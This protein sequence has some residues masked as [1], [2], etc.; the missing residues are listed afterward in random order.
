MEDHE[1]G[2]CSG[3][4]LHVSWTTDT[5]R[6]RRNNEDACLALPEKGLLAVSDG[7]GGEFAGEVASRFVIQWLPRLLER[8][9]ES[10]PDGDLGAVEEALRDVLNDLNHRL[11]SESS[12][13]DGLNKMG[14][15]LTMF[16]VR[17]GHAHVAHLGDSR[18]YLCRAGRLTKLS[19]DHGVVGMLLEQ[20]VISLDEARCH[21]LRG[22]LS[23]YMGM[24]GNTKAEVATVELEDGDR[25]MLCTDG[26]TDGL[27]DQDIEGLLAA[28]QDLGSA[29]ARLVEAAKHASG[30]DNIT[31][32]LA[33]WHGR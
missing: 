5:G 3:G 14:A 20:G 4:G 29:C 27:S 7:M 15:T 12:T 17:R 13:L 26:L 21:P 1:S 18:A 31:V 9:V 23:R 30:R 28:E 2:Q 25:L 16:L 6:M 19:H 33:E 11:R 32:V 22:Q 8:H 24:G 10:V